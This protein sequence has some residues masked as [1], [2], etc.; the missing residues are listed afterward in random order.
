MKKLPLILLLAVLPG[1]SQPEA[2]TVVVPQ[3]TA[4]QA[5]ASPAP[6]PVAVAPAPDMPTPPPPT[7]TQVQTTTT[8][9]TTSTEEAAQ[10]FGNSTIA[11]DSGRWLQVDVYDENGRALDTLNLRSGDNQEIPSAARKVEIRVNGKSV[12]IDKG[13]T[14]IKIN[15]NEDLEIV[16]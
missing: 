13:N 4:P 11:N 7:K 10:P 8:T 9:T 6:T 14:K 3:T 16:G 2:E 12:A 5:P 1:C 15:Q